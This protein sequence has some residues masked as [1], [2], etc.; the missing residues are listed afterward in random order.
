MA[1][2]LRLYLNGVLIT[3]LDETG[4]IGISEVSDLIIGNIGELEL[5]NGTAPAPYKG[6]LDELEFF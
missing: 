1:H 6:M 5:Q 2:R 4:V 3:E